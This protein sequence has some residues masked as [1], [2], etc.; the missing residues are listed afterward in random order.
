MKVRVVVHIDYSIEPLGL[1]GI[2]DDLVELVRGGTRHGEVKEIYLEAKSPSDLET[3][4]V[5]VV[6]FNDDKG[7]I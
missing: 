3:K 5:P 1:K 6:L 2:T 7:F 4:P